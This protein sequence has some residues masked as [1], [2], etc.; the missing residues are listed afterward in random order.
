MQLYVQEVITIM[1]Q[2]WNNAKTVSEAEQNDAETGSKAKQNKNKPI[3]KAKLAEYVS[4]AGLAEDEASGL[5]GLSREMAERL[6]RTSLRLVESRPY[7]HGTGARNGVPFFARYDT[8]LWADK[9]HALFAWGDEGTNI[10]RGWDS[11]NFRQL[12]RQLH[13]V[14]AEERGALQAEAF[15]D[16]VHTVAA[17]VLWVIPQYNAGKLSVMY[18]PKPGH[19]KA[20]R[21]KINDMN[22]FERTN[23]IA[24]QV[25]EEYIASVLDFEDYLDDPDDVLYGRLIN[26]NVPRLKKRVKEAL[27]PLNLRV[28]Y[29]KKEP[30]YLPEDPGRIHVMLYLNKAAQIQEE[31]AQAQEE[32]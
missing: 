28:H 22:V 30:I 20:T 32:T 3:S 24:A 7:T 26:R 23:W 11:L 8:G 27:S 4:W 9:L 25:D 18:D 6:G 29:D 19:S 13:T 17:R 31:A 14:I 1:A 2:R 5:R 16:A 15:I 10:K 12:T 21:A